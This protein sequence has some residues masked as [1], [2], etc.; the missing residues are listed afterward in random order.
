MQLKQEQLEQL[1]ALQKKYEQAIYDLG[2]LE[3]EKSFIL[4]DLE[5]VR[6]QERKLVDSL[7]KEYGK[8]TIDLENGTFVP[9]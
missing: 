8:G 6:D 1:K 3:L 5:V 2:R 4:E 7:T 9:E